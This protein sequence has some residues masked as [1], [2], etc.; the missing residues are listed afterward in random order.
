MKRWFRLLAQT[1]G[2]AA[3]LVVGAVAAAALSVAA[4]IAL[5]A[6]CLLGFCIWL[7][8]DAWEGWL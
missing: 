5:L 6:A 7:F 8:D 3:A 4:V 2:M 1:S